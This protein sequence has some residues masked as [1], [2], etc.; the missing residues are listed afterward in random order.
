MHEPGGYE[1]AYCEHL[2]NLKNLPEL[3]AKQE[4]DACWYDCG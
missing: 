3:S 4:K 1:P 2:V